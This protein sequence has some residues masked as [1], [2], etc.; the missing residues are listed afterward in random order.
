MRIAGVGAGPD[1]ERDGVARQ[2]GRWAGEAQGREDPTGVALRRAG[3]GLK[4]GSRRATKK[5][6]GGGEENCSGEGESVQNQGELEVEGE[7]G[8]GGRDL[9][10]PKMTYTFKRNAM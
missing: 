10:G 5:P 2:E 4:K 7:G 8:E 3:W 9:K 6:P 1:V